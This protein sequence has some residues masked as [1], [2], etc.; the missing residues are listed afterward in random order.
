MTD[1]DITLIVPVSVVEQ[2]RQL[3]AMWQGGAGMFVTPLYTGEDVTHYIS[4]GKMDAVVTGWLMGDTAAL[5]T[6]IHSR[7]GDTTVE[8]IQALIDACDI[9][10][11]NPHEAI[12][13]MGLSLNPVEDV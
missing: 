10:Q 2:V 5:V 1:T 8:Q 6:E 4:T 12:A 7:G 9:S 3:A 11:E 13:R